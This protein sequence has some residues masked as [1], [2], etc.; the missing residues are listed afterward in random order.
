[1]PK[2]GE[3]R[4]HLPFPFKGLSDNVAF[5]EQEPGTTRDS[6]NMR[7]INPTNGRVTGSQ[8][9]GLSKFNS[10]VVSSGNKIQDLNSVIVDNRAVTYSSEGASLGASEEEWLVQTPSATASAVVATDRQSNVYALDGRAGIVKYNSEGTEIF[11]FSLPVADTAHRVGELHIDEF[12][13]VY[14]GVSSGGRSTTARM[15]KMLPNDDSGL[16]IVWQVTPGGFVEEIDVLGAKL[17]VGCNFPDFN[18]GRLQIYEGIDASEPVKVLDQIIPYPVNGLSVNKGGESFTCHDQNFRPTSLGAG[19]I[20]PGAPFSHPDVYP[21]VV[22]WT[23]DLLSNASQRIWG[24]W[25]ASTVEASD[26]AENELRDGAECLILRDLSGNGRHLFKNTVDA[27]QNGPKVNFKGLSGRQTLRFEG[28]ESLI[29]S[30]SDGYGVNSA[31]SQ[32]GLLPATANSMFCAFYVFRPASQ[33]TINGSPEARCFMFQGDELGTG[34][35]HA[36]CVDRN[37]GATLPG[38]ANANSI[39]YY[40][41]T[42]SVDAGACAGAD[43]ASTMSHV[44]TFAQFFTVLWDGGIDPNDSSSGTTRSLVRC[45]GGRFLDRFEGEP[46]GSSEATRIGID[47]NGDLAQFHGELCEIIVLQRQDYQTTAEP[48]VLTHDANESTSVAQTINEMTQI[49]GYLAYKW[50]LPIEFQN[51]PANNLHPFYVTAGS[52]EDTFGPPSDETTVS[53]STAHGHSM[54]YMPSICKWDSNGRLV[55]C[56]NA[57]SGA[58][59]EANSGGVGWGVKVNRLTGDVYS[60]GRSDVDSDTAS[61]IDYAGTA[62]VRM[63]KDE[64]DDFSD[65]T[66]DDAWRVTGLSGSAT[67]EHPRIDVDKFG[68]V[69]FPFGQFLYVYDNEGSLV[70]V[71]GDVAADLL[72]VAIDPDVPDFGSQTGLDRAEFMYIGARGSGQAGT[73][74]NLDA[75]YAEGVRRVRLLTE[76]GQT[77]SPRTVTN[78]VVSNGTIQTFVSGATAHS[79]PTGGSSALDSSSQYVQSAVLYQKIYFVDGRNSVIFDPVA[80]TVT[81]WESESAGQIPA[82]P[83][84]IESWRGR[85]VLARAPDDPQNW[86]MSRKDDP[87]NWDYF[88]AVPTELDA[89]AGNNSPAGLVPDLVNTMVPYSDD[90]LIFGGDHSIWALVGD[91][92]AGGRLDL[93]TDVTGMS[94]GRPWAKDPNG[95]LYFFGSRGGLYRLVPGSKPDR[96]SLNRIERR[97]Q[98]VDLANYH[99]RLAYNYRDEGV[100]IFQIPFGSGGTSVKHWFYEIKTDSFWE[101]Q[102]GTS[103]TTTVQPTA[104]YLLDADDFDDRT[105]LLGGE[106]SYIR[107][108]SASSKNDDALAIDAQVLMGPLPGRVEGFDT[109]FSGLNV[110]LTSTLHGGR[111]EMFAAEDPED[112]GQIRRNGVLVP[113]RNPPKWDRVTGPYCWVRIRNSALDESFAVERVFIHGSPAGWA[114]PR[115]AS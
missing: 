75:T 103:T 63:L 92:A 106:D 8:R 105:L 43:Q 2:T 32:K 102:F 65:S 80:D 38:T 22:A 93:V 57:N 47:P 19:K 108:W 95:V 48:K 115:N 98:D 110:V 23:P 15:W 14:A 67:W 44:N 66:G 46:L 1:M 60:V 85:L 90:L 61:V 87:L 96:V 52:S 100:H 56:Y 54:E 7:G 4:L 9:S 20:R 112:V 113:G 42:D 91:P 33:T 24:W 62:D 64:G 27:D 12:D 71:Y 39:T 29:S 3:E 111:Y 114:R 101:D 25:D 30:A 81:A 40:A 84:L 28:S 74:R 109:Q 18:Q 88:P 70:T 31:Q 34:T 10:N 99:M 37:C 11:R 78:T 83:R 97:L 35:D 68:N 73:S 82:R 6:L 53:V 17:Y 86:F 13:C 77:G 26:T 76:T 55:W 58:E 94:W 59:S 107:Q 104:V 49:E 16:E 51:N 41:D 36:L 45:L 50:G 89:V 69:Y 79:T 5:G 21:P 72:A